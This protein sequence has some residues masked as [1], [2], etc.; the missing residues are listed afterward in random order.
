MIK[1]ILIFC[2]FYYSIC[3]YCQDTSKTVINNGQEIV[4]KGLAIKNQRDTVFD[5]N[6]I[7]SSFIAI[8]DTEFCIK[9]PGGDKA[10]IKY[11][12]KNIVLPPDL[13][14]R[15]IEGR[16]YASFYV[17]EK[18]KVENVRIEESLCEDIDK[19]VLRVISEMPN[20]KW[21]CKEGPQRH[22]SIKRYVPIIIKQNRV[23]K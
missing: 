17:N 1:V 11:L 10:F 8:D 16:V 12:K 14:E 23:K 2:C 19:E 22:I 18:G 4:I 21:D 7:D 9:F 13:K 6:Y 3:G 20:W 5:K 15:G